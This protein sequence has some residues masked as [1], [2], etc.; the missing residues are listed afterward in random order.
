MEIEQCS[1]KSPLSQGRKERVEKKWKEKKE[2]KNFPE[3][4]KNEGTMYPNLWDTVKAV[5]RRKFI[6][7]SAYI[8]KVKKAHTND[9]KASLKALEQQ[10]IKTEEEIT[11]NN[12]IEG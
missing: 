7:L 2:I 9:L 6:A 4:N 11:E 1:I 5:L 12:K 10:Q 3:F 8:K